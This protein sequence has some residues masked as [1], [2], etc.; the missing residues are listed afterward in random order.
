VAGIPVT[1]VE[2]IANELKS[3]YLKV[4][5]VVQKQFQGEL[6]H[7]P[8]R[9]IFAMAEEMRDRLVRTRGIEREWHGLLRERRGDLWPEA[10]GR[11]ERE[12]ERYQEWQ[13]ALDRSLQTAKDARDTF[14][15]RLANEIGS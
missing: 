13:E 11:Y 7:D 15:A 9:A 2:R 10:Y 4:V 5:S 3:R 14:A 6:Q 8:Y 12:T 1:D